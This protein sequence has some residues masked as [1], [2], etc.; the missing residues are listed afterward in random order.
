MYHGLFL[1]HTP[2]GHIYFPTTFGI[3]RHPFPFPVPFYP[4]TV[5]CFGCCSRCWDW[6]AVLEQCP[7]HLHVMHLRLSLQQPQCVILQV[8][9]S[10]YSQKLLTE[11]HSYVPA[12]VECDSAA[13]PSY[14]PPFCPL[15]LTNWLS[16]FSRPF[17]SSSHPIFG[18]GVVDVTSELSRVLDLLYH[19]LA[20]LSMEVTPYPPH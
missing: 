19:F 4:L 1:Y 3:T 16:N 9:V 20:Q 14:L 6:G 11:G 17:S 7:R 18:G 12:A 13:V 10:L 5:P 15:V 2:P 8:D